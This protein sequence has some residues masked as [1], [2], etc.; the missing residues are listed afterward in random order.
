MDQC[1]AVMG[2]TTAP[3]PD[4]MALDAPGKQCESCGYVL[5]F[6]Y[7]NVGTGGRRSAACDVCRDDARHQRPWTAAQNNKLRDAARGVINCWPRLMDAMTEDDRVAFRA[8]LATLD[9]GHD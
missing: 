7:F 2:A 8:L 5:P 6:S 3:R 9:R 4:W 1:I